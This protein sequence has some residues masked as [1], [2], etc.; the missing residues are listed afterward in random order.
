MI[1]SFAHYVTDRFLLADLAYETLDR[2]WIETVPETKVRSTVSTLL[3]E[4]GH[5]PYQCDAVDEF[6]ERACATDLL[7]LRADKMRWRSPRTPVYLA[8]LGLYQRY[9]HERHRGWRISNENEQVAGAL[10]Q[11]KAVLPRWQEPVA[12]LIGHHIQENEEVC[13]IVELLASTTPSLATWYQERLEEGF[14]DVPWPERKF[15]GEIAWPL[16]DVGF[17]RDAL[18]D[19]DPDTRHQ[20]VLILGL[21]RIAGVEEPLLYLLSDEDDQVRARAAWALGR[22]GAVDG[23]KSLI[24]ML[25]DPSQRVRFQ[26]RRALAIIQGE[27]ENTDFTAQFSIERASRRVLFSDDEPD[28]L[29]LYELILKR[30][31]Y[32]CLCAPGGMQTL[33]LARCQQPDLIATDML[34]SPMTGTD[35]VFELKNEVATR[36]IPIV[37]VSAHT[38][39]L[40][41]LGFFAGADADIQKPFGPAQ[42]VA[43]LDEMLLG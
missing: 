26:V 12:I 40:R 5:R 27:G 7:I 20:A 3:A 13:R 16:G 11:E 23:S 9:F 36:E 30:A 34:N 2:G 22:L 19:S 29:A 38:R 31:G 42:L 28:L 41:W 10:L 24:P 32:E 18:Q 8:A 15:L 21:A 43:L 14:F 17:W 1:A 37:L 4:S 25:R 35:L 39:Y 6:L 33:E